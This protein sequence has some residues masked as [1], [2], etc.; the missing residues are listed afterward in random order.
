M[1]PIIVLAIRCV[2]PASTRSIVVSCSWLTMS[3]IGPSQVAGGLPSIAVGAESRAL[4]DHDDLHPDPLF[5]QPLGLRVDPLG[6]V[7]E[8]QAGSVAR[9]DQFGSG[10]HISTD[11]PDF[12][13]V[14]VEHLR[15]LD[16][17]RR[18]AGDLVDDVGRRGRG[19]WPEP[20]A[21]AVVRCRSRTRGC[22]SSSRRDPRRS[23]RRWSACP[24]AMPSSAARHRR[25]R[26]TPGAAVSP[27]GLAASSSNIVASCPAPPDADVDSVDRC[28]RRIELSVEVGEADHRQRRESVTV[29]QSFQQHAA[30]AVLRHRNS[31]HEGDGGREVD[32]AHDHE[33]RRAE[34][35]GRRPGTWR[36]C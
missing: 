20:A 6:F 12:D 18:L 11:H 19:S 13:A 27:E 16:P 35:P 24:R 3:M 30:L 23:R 4:V 10:S 26:R 1:R 5:P 28:R 2:C 36:A 14:D 15:R 22:R 29:P 21:P 17:V 9:G 25:C 32:A 33:C 7:E 34:F 8:Q 31:E